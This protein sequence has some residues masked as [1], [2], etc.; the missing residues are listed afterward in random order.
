MALA[1][2]MEK[3]KNGTECS[4]NNAVKLNNS[5]NKKIFLRRHSSHEFFH[6]DNL[7]PKISNNNDDDHCERGTVEKIHKSK[8]EVQLSSVCKFLDSVYDTIHVTVC[9]PIKYL[10]GVPLQMEEVDLVLGK[11]LEG[12]LHHILHNVNPDDTN[13]DKRPLP[14][15]ETNPEFHSRFASGVDCDEVYNNLLIGNG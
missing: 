7:A 6:P 10:Q 8:T 2:W 4:K 5:E 13:V 12:D 3:Y 11:T 1:K 9:P 15:I 14:G